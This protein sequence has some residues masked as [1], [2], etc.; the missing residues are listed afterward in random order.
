V[1][2][3]PVD[4]V[5]VRAWGRTVG[6]V[7]WDPRAR[8]YAFEY[9][10][11]WLRAG[12]E[13]SPLL[14]PGRPGAYAFPA[15]DPVTYHRLPPM[16]ADALPDRFG[17][18]LVDAWLA[19]QGILPDQVTPLDR[20][21][22]TAERGMGALEFHPPAEATSEPTAVQLADLV[23]TARRAIRGELS[24][25]LD[26]H[27]ALRQLIQVG[28]SAGGARPKAVVA[29][30][31][32]TDQIRSGQTAAPPGFEHWLVKLD[33]VG[34]D[35]TREADPATAP[36]T[37]AGGGYG[38]IEYAYHLMAVAAG[39][40]MTECRLLPEGP[41]THFLTR[42]FDR[43][44]GGARHHVLTLCGLAH[45]DFNMAATHSYD[46]YLQVVA[47]LGLGP[48]DRQ[49]A[50]RRVVFNVAAVNRD[51]HTKNLSFLAP[52]GGDWQLAPA[53]DLIHAHN[54]HGEWTHQ[55]QMGVGGRFDGISLADLA[56]LGDR[57]LVPRHRAVVAEVL[58]AVDR[59]PSFAEAAGVPGARVERVAADLERHRPR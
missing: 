43:G 16:V 36:S 8:C 25:S 7:A 1:S 26:A 53:Y 28:T 44:P 32:E 55:H 41:R 56:D 10:D 59:W 51:D 46:Q 29:Y 31:P 34:G 5:E 13:L 23:A 14:M 22:Y 6:A 17:N 35:P 15:L 24:T 52:E 18:A 38:R 42:R 2:Y 27:E 45:L 50:F 12:Q 40:E 54:P 20:L 30:H 9:D 21:A 57:H 11:A 33:G 4:L 47:Q 58:A 3:A 49:Q 48:Q 37:A 19:T 39:V